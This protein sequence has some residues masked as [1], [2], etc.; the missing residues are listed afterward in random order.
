MGKTYILKRSSGDASGTSR[1]TS[2]HISRNKSVTVV[3][4]VGRTCQ[5]SEAGL[6]VED[7]GGGSAWAGLPAT[8]PPDNS[9]S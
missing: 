7:G 4:T 2:V 6:N 8:E 5:L 3:Y 1:V 9:D